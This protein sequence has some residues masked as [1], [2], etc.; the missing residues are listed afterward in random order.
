M[1]SDLSSKEKLPD[2]LRRWY[3]L[4]GEPRFREAADEIER[5]QGEL[6]AAE[7]H[8]KILRENAASH[9]PRANTEGEVGLAADV[10]PGGG[11]SASASGEAHAPE[12]SPPQP[13]LDARYCPFN[14]KPCEPIDLAEETSETKSETVMS[15]VREHFDAQRDRDGYH[16]E[17]ERLEFA[18][19]A[20]P[21]PSFDMLGELKKRL[22]WCPALVGSNP[23]EWNGD[24]KCRHCGGER[25]SAETSGARDE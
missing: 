19:P 16:S 21:G 6:D 7:Q 4:K 1:S 23:H 10:G 3:C 2:W 15:K 8:V 14:H 18:P 5:L 12:L 20:D 9:E 22:M 25:P 24:G 17:L 13:P 11:A